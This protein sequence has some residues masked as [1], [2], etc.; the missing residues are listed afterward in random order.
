MNLYDKVLKRIYE[1]AKKLDGKCECSEGETCEECGTFEE[2]TGAGAI[3]ISALPL[4]ARAE[5][6]PE[7]RATRKIKYKDG[8]S[9]AKKMNSLSKKSL[10]SSNYPVPKKKSLVEV[11]KFL[12]EVKTPRLENLS[13]DRIISLL[14]HMI[15]DTPTGYSFDVT[16]KISGQAIHVGLEGTPRGNAV[17]T[18]AKE[19]YE[20]AGKNIFRR[21]FYHSSGSSKHVKRAFMKYKRLKPGERK[22]FAMEVIKPDHKKPD[23]IAY[24][25]PYGK[26]MVTVFKG[27]F[28]KADAQRLSGPV[29]R[30][31]SLE[32]FTAEDIKKMPLD[33]ISSETENEIRALIEKVQNAPERGFKT[34]IK[35]EVSSRLMHLIKDIYGGSILNS[36]SPIEG[37]A[38]NITT[39]EGENIFMKIPYEGYNALQAIQAAI[40]AEFKLNHGSLA[41]E[42]V[43]T[44]EYASSY[45]GRAKMLHD[46]IKSPA[47]KV[48]FAYKVLK[49]I[50]FLNEKRTLHKNLRTFMSPKDFKQFCETLLSAIETDDPKLFGRAMIYI[51]KGAGSSR[52]LYTVKEGDNFN[53]PESEALSAKIDEIL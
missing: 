26:T 47:G 44:Q 25:V 2:A 5:Y 21:R 7:G 13:K 51:S 6:P 9:K 34:F 43:V 33:N 11:Y 8:N 12:F 17:Y 30:G 29:G 53:S 52:H 20:N 15:K 19:S 3:A 42:Y 40:Y 23:Y 41:R 35:K 22:E 39:P 49:Y 46:Y 50:Q 38:V 4:G 27:D 37:V 16:E 48:S 24:K 32:F 28:T 31:V 45:S 14:K 36:E 1:E 18:A 10:S